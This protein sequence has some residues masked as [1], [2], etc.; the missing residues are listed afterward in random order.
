MNKDVK[1]LS[2]QFIE[3]SDYILKMVGK[4]RMDKCMIGLILGS[5][6]G[7][8]ADCLQDTVVMD[9][10]DIPNW[11]QST[12]VGHEGKL[13]VGHIPK[14]KD[15]YVM[16][17]KGRK[18]YYECLDMDTVTFPVR[19]F[20]EVGL[21]AMFTTNAT[22]GINEKFTVGDFMII[23]D[24]INMMPNPCLGPNIVKHGPR[25]HDMSKAYDPEFRACIKKAAEEEKIKVQEGVN[26]A[27]SGPS[28]ETP[29]E[30]RMF[31]SWG[32][33]NIGMSTAPE[34]IVGRHCRLRCVGISCITNM[35]A[36]VIKDTT[37]NH[38]EVEE[39]AAR[40]KPYFMRLL[41]SS[42]VK[43]HYALAE[44]VE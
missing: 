1:R 4:E 25:F 17:M 10:E 8:F 22:G 42:L 38:K 3:T 41:S 44:N 19:I 36:G 21:K 30:I 26:V 5:G 11:P 43:I 29:A 9:Y 20:K 27:V 28:Y 33:D 23:T 32:A 15:I 16:T 39:V 37:L 14:Y 18:H 31:Q 2:A 7:C 35:A 6:L 40:R 13:V 12:V 24:H 34:V